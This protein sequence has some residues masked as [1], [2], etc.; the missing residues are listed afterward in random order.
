MA[1]G[2]VFYGSEGGVHV[3]RFTGRVGFN[4][5]PALERF[6]TDLFERDR[7]R[8]LVLDL[9]GTE[10]M[11]STI[12]GVLARLAV[13]MTSEGR[14]RPVVVT[15]EGEVREILNY[16]GFDDILEMTDN[17]AETCRSD[18][19]LLL[20]ETSNPAI[21]KRTALDAHRMLMELQ[22]ENRGLF[23]QL[24]ELLEQEDDVNDRFRR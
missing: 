23:D 10:H 7:P 2:R 1:D 4:L 6:I 19:Q 3:L 17:P 8:H 12:L 9:T 21:M 20:A 11:D 5:G 24:V 14:D 15:R 18:V 22:E 16:L 13:R